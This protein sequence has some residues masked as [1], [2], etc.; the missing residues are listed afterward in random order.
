M[1]GEHQHST[2]DF[3]RGDLSNR[4]QPAPWHRKVGDN[5]GG[6]ECP[7]SLD[8]L[9]SVF[10]F[11]NH[12]HILLCFQQGPEAGADNAVIVC[13]KHPDRQIHGIGRC[14]HRR[15]LLVNE[16]P[17]TSFKGPMGIETATR[18][19]F[20]T[21]CLIAN[22]PPTRTAR[23][24]IPN[25]PSPSPRSSRSMV[26]PGTNPT[27]LSSIA[28]STR[29]ADRRKVIVALVALAC[30][31]TFVSA[32]CATRY[33]TSSSSGDRRSRIPLTSS[34]TCMSVFSENR[35]ARSPNASR[36]PRS[37]SAGGRSSSARRRT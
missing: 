6:F 35:W 27:P 13:Q 1:D 24:S 9:W 4:L 17:V 20:G 34:S 18:V 10:G 12:S 8:C 15:A 26:L 19:P 7:G 21:S 37:S 2:L 23:S 25:T 11:G 16:A 36:T 29:S 22:V 5:D 30:L 14:C 3:Q 28:S 32:S 33:S 31:A